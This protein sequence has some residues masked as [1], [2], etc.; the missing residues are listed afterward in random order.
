VRIWSCSPAAAAIRIVIAGIRQAVQQHKAA[1]DIGDK[2]KQLLE[3]LLTQRENIR[4]TAED[5]QL[6]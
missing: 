1:G 2:E 3:G 6:F 4:R 5:K